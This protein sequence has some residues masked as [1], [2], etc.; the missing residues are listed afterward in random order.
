MK[1]SKIENFL[2]IDSP[3]P[4]PPPVPRSPHTRA[5]GPKIQRLGTSNRLQRKRAEKA[6]AAKE[7]ERL[8]EIRRREDGRKAVEMAEHLADASVSGQGERGAWSR[9]L[10]PV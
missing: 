7:A 3:Y 1:T 8:G 5:Q 6:A 10:C 4:S 9:P 2:H